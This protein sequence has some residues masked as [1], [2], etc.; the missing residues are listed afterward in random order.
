MNDIFSGFNK[1]FS[2]DS[3][4][5]NGMVSPN[6]SKKT[7]TPVLTT[8]TTFKNTA[9][10]TINSIKNYVFG[11]SNNTIKTNKNRNNSISYL[12]NKN[13]KKSLISNVKSIISGESGLLQTIFNILLLLLLLYL[14][15]RVLYLLFGPPKDINQ[16]K[17][18]P[19]FLCNSCS[20]D[21]KGKC[22]L[23]GTSGPHDASK[24]YV[25]SPP[26]GNKSQE[27]FYIP[28]DVLNKDETLSH[29]YA[30]SFWIK[31]NSE[32]WNDK[33]YNGIKHKQE[34]QKIIEENYDNCDKNN[35]DNDNNGN[36]KDNSGRKCILYRGREDK[37]V[38][39]FWLSPKNNDIWCQINTKDDAGVLL[40][41]GVML[42]NIPLNEWFNIT[43]V[44]D[45]RS[46]EV[47]MNDKLVKTISLYGTPLESSGNLHITN[48]G[49]FNGN[50]AYLQYFN[51]TLQPE[52]IKS[53]HNYYLKEIKKCIKYEKKPDSP[54]DPQPQPQPQPV[55]DCNYM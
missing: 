46:Y 9:S 17:T 11:N 42:K 24:K 21:E 30:T 36:T 45:N 53:L 48:N 12:Q 25:Y 44:I 7:K 13:K 6:Y 15:Y 52:R 29:S 32:T 5:T 50:L 28:S 22:H 10:S 8:T 23:D 3:S 27:R 51:T 55:C 16:S 54:S 18:E 2:V 31:V 39:G 26:D 47:Y 41:E 19:V 14:I 40:E 34:N 43:A 38:F 33:L 4:S 49:G 1:L 35:N 20:D 37:Q